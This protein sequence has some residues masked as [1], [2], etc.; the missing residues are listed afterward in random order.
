MFTSYIKNLNDMVFSTSESPEEQQST[1][2]LGRIGGWLSPWKGNGPKSPTGNASPTSDQAPKSEGEEESERPVRLRANNQEWEEEKEQSSNPNPLFLSRDIS[3]YEERNAAQSAHRDGVIVSS[4]ET[5]EGGSKKEEF[6]EYRQERKGQREERSNRSSESGNPEKNSRHL[7]H[8]S[9]SSSKQGVVRDSDPTHTQPQAH[10]GRTLHVYLEDTEVTHSG[11]ETCAGQEIVH[12]EVTKK[13]IT[14]LRKGPSSSSFDLN[15]SSKSEE[16]RRTNVSP[17]KGADSYYSALVGVSLKSPK[18]SQSEAESEE[19]TEANRMGRKNAAR[20]K[21][22]QNSQGNEGNTPQEN[23]PPTALPVPEG[24][25]TSDNSLTTPQGKGAET[26]MGESSVNSSSSSQPNP[27]TQASPEGME[28]ET[29]CPDA[30]KQLDNFQDSNSVIAASL[31][32]VTNR[33]SDMEDDDSLYRVER[34]TE[35]PESKRRSLKVSR[36]ELKLFTKNVPLEKSPAGGTDEFKTAV[37]KTKDGEKDKPNTETDGRQ[38]QLKKIDEEPNPAA[39]RI[40]GKINLFEHPA[41]RVNK[42]TFQSQRSADVSPARKPTEKMKEEFVSS[43]KRSK[44]A[45]RYAMAMSGT[46][47]AVREKPMTIK[48]RAR[49]FTEASK[50]DDRPAVSQKPAMTGMS[51]RSLL[52]VAAAAS[53]QLDNQG[54]LDTKERIQKQK[55]EIT[56]KPD[57]QDTIAVGVKM[58]I[59]KEQPTDSRISNTADSK[60]AEKGMKSNSLET[61]PTKETSDSAE[62][63]NSISPQSKSP[64][65]MGSR[66]KRKKGRGPDSP[67]SP[68]GENK[69]DCSTSKAELT[70]NK[71]H[72]VDD[73]EKAASASKTQEVSLASEKAQGNT[74][75]KQSLSDTKGRA[76]K[77]EI[78]VVDEQKERLAVSVTNEKINKLDNRPEGLP[79]P[80]VNKDQPDTAAGRSGTK[81]PIDQSPVILPRKQEQA[82]GNRLSFT[83]RKE[84]DSKDCKETSASSPSPVV[85]Q[86]PEKTRSMKQGPPVEHP[87]LEKELPTQSASKSEVKVKL[88]NKK[89]TGQKQQPLNKDTELINQTV[90]EDVRNLEKVEGEKRNQTEKE[91]KDMPQQLPRPDNNT[92]KAK[93]SDSRQFISG[94]KESAARDD[95]IINAEIK[96]ERKVII[97]PEM[98]QPEPL[99]QSS[100][101]TGTLLDLPAPKQHVIHT[102]S[103]HPEETAVC[104]VT[105]TN[106]AVSVTKSEKEPSKRS[107]AS[108]VPSELQQESPKGPG[109]ETKPQPHSVSVEKTENLPDDSCAHGA[110]D[111]EFS[112]SESITK[113]TTAAEKWTVKAGDGTPALIAAQ[114][115]S[116]KRASVK[117][118]TPMSPSKS[119]RSKGAGRVDGESNSN[120]I[121]VPAVVK[122]S[123]DVIK[124]ARRQREDSKS[125]ESTSDITSVKGA[126]KIAHGP[127]DREASS[128]IVNVAGNSAEK[129][130]H[131]QSNDVS[132]VANGDFPQQL[133]TV[134]KELVNNKPSPQANKPTPDT[135]Q[136]SSMKKLHLPRGLNRDDASAPQDAPSSWLDVDFPKRKLK[137]PVPKLSYSGSE[138]NLL[139]TSGDLDDDDFIE[140]IKNLCSPFSLPPRKHNVLRTPQPLFAMPAIREDRHEKTFDP[141]EFK[142]GLRKKDPFSVDTTPSFLSR[143][144]NKDTKSGMKPARA[145]L[146]DRSMLMSSLDTRSRLRDK[147]DNDEED[148]KEEKEEQVKVKSRLEGSCV[149]SSLSSSIFR[150]K[151]NG[152]QTQV[153]GTSSGDVSPSEA[154]Q[155]SPPPLSQPSSTAPLRDTL[156]LSSREEAQ[157]VEA[158]VDDSGPPFPSF[159]DIKLPDYLEKYL[160]QEPAK[161]GMEQVKPELI[162]KM[163][164][165]A[166][167]DEADWAVKLPRAVSPFSPGIPPI[168]PPTLPTIPAELKEPPAQPRGTLSRNIRT[169]KGFHKRPGKMVLFEKAQFSGQAHEIFGDVADA[170]SLRLSPLVSVM[171]VRGCWVL[172]EKPDF[173]GRCIA[174]EEGG[175]ELTNMWAEPV[176][177]TEPENLP[178]MQM[179][180]IR[181]AVRDYSLPHIDLFTEP[182][183]HGRVTPYH[184]DTIETGAFGVPLSTASIQ[185][186]SGVWLLF[187]DPGFQGMIAVLEPGA[188]PVPEAWGF[189]SPFIGSLRP[190]KMG[191][192]KVENPNE[193]K[194]VVFEKPGLE[195][196]CL[197]IDSD[198]FSICESQGDIATD[199]E[200]IDSTQ[201]KSMGSLKIIGG[202]WVGYSEPGFEGQQFILEEGEYLDCSDWGDSEQLLSLRPILGDFM[203]P[204]LKM[205]SDRDF[206]N[207][208]VNIDVSV[209]V[210]NMEDTGYGVQ[211]QSVDVISGVWVLFEELGF[212]GESFVVEKGLYGCPEDWGA[213]KP[214]VA[215]AMPVR[216]DDFDNA[217]KFKVQLFSDPGFEGSV[218]PLEDSAASLQ[219]GV[220]VSSCKVLAGSWL[221][222]EGQD[223]TGRMYV[224][225][226]GGYP[227]LRAM[228]CVSASSSILSLQIVGF[229]FSLPSITLFERS[230]LWGKRV[231]LTEASVNL[232][233]AGGCSRVQS[234]LVEGGMWILYE[235]I[236]YRGPQILLKPGE[237]PDWRRFSSWQKIGSLR[238]LTQK[239]VHFR[240]RNRHSGLMMSVTGDLEEV[241][242]LRIQET[243]ETDGFDQIWF[244]QDGHLH[245]KLLEECCVGPTGSV[246]MVGSRVGLIP[247][248]ENHVHLWSIT[249]EGFIR[250]TPTSDLVLE[251][252]GGQHYDKTQVILKTLD[253]SKPQQKWD[254]EVI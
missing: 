71:Q 204:H 176:P 173:Q 73:T 87:K 53:T 78:L 160:P 109:T 253:P 27:T 106:E 75:N 162:G 12:T 117:E 45:E 174:L 76:I 138:S 80:S 112:S 177:E 210:L 116:E 100:E 194:A 240:L 81:T 58:S 57:G 5:A 180:S 247:H 77:K 33:G 96:D 178:P 74:S 90:S 190:L 230:G 186:H 122:V 157:A 243:E 166:P 200:N 79:E 175:I 118:H 60:T 205:F 217:A 159:N 222:F 250:Y 132:L 54:K 110:N 84:N 52:F 48:E 46:A 98:M 171:V 137:V 212:C 183:G 107:Q 239:R 130:L 127:S 88:Q 161:Q 227:N 55:S 34:K 62:L 26:H 215:S 229:E 242:L 202:F 150:G 191:G 65:R 25:L 196:S 235:G 64:T 93:V 140:K 18:D 104:A 126:K 223:F 207:L 4:T 43:E 134:G 2:V 226:V 56:L 24:I 86:P 3:P 147:E 8:L 167:G 231:V 241:K 221:A 213:L 39:G 201:L 179:G 225:E 197:E 158:V 91:N 216:V 146:A 123:G 129:T 187:S 244:Y 249:P 188:Y 114:T 66:P 211:T 198:V 6:V 254:V 51:Q 7:T 121:S 245:C 103:T 15:S 44:S 128:S 142:F 125:T 135:T 224:L 97:K 38:H 237:V 164:T 101:K 192:F 83:Q 70:G 111:S 50:S 49:N 37:K 13:D 47:P 143:L 154:P 82:G 28:S 68:N 151:R 67:I 22:R 32:C 42:Q 168:T 149:L 92:T 208:G 169:V 19:Q 218:L 23:M 170:T 172:Y 113:A 102:K 163:P 30:V 94:T 220:S 232:Q 16:I 189:T 29:S 248:P 99:S 95:E 41:A 219:D 20:K 252:K 181:L 31:A 17:A 85:E 11:K 228:G 9:S 14:I 124:P 141:D 193:V 184:D 153:D 35:T 203:S 182:E 61:D 233:L 156:A 69:P 119:E 145:S 36:S 59:P 152:G 139:D 1:G 133:N 72:Q 136:H 206:G 246:T 148:V 199:G 89:D 214:R 234:V 195:G 21:L 108:C 10:V 185:V 165:P 155:L 131:S 144:Q 209:P 63:T 40:A 238:P 251:V 105:Q 236:N 120:A 115:L